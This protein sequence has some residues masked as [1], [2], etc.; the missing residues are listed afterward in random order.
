[1]HLQIYT[2]ELTIEPEIYSPS[3]DT[4]GNYVDAVP[5]SIKHGILCP[6]GTRKDHIYDSTTKFSIHV[7]TA[8]HKKWLDKVNM[9]KSNYYVEYEKL[10]RTV[11]NQQ[12]MI[13]KYDNEINSK[14]C[15]IAQLTQQNLDLRQQIDKMYNQTTEDL[16]GIDN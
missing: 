2:M 7:K 16:L 6:C 14:N 13:T 8:T 12:Q 4:L 11:S 3:I 15:V 5:R 9:D 1:M 10:R